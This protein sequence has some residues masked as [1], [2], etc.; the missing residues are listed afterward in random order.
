[1]NKK[2]REYLE[3]QLNNANDSSGK[4]IITNIIQN[5]EVLEIFKKNTDVELLKANENAPIFAT[6]L[7]I[8]PFIIFFFYVVVFPI[9]KIFYKYT[10]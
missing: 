9:I 6:V 10:I 2:V 5:L 8:K 1:M 7:R 3:W 4:E